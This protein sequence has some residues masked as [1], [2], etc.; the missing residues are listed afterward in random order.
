MVFEADAWDSTVSFAPDILVS[1]GGTLELTFADGVDLADQIGRTIDLFDWSGVSPIGS[2]VISTPYLWN[3]SS[4]YTTGEITLI[5][6][7]EPATFVLVAL[8][9]LGLVVRSRR[10]PR[11]NYPD[12]KAAK[13]LTRKAME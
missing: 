4:L 10:S 9:L 13:N 1:L 12:S 11:K 5:A 6:I 7:P 2:F 8:G 3:L